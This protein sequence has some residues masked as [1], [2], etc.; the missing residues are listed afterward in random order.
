MSAPQVIANTLGLELTTSREFN[1]EYLYQPG[2]TKK[3]L[4]TVGDDYFCVSKS[5]PKDDVGGEWVKHR[6]QFWAE[7]KNTVLW[8]ATP[9]TNE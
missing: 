2:R 4:Y 1:N 5:K 7:Q 3:P 9:T 8:V 6:D